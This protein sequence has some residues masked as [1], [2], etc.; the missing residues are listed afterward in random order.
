MKLFNDT[1]L[2]TNNK[3]HRQNLDLPD[4]DLMLHEGF[5]DKKESDHYYA[6]LLKNTPW[7]E[8]ELTVY[9]KTHTIPRM[10]AWYE[11]KSNAGADLSAP[12]WT[13]ELLAIKKKV[14]QECGHKFNSVLLNL[15]RDGKDGVGWHSDKEED[16][17]S[18]QVIASVSFGET[19]LFKL[20]HKTQK[21]LPVQELPL[22]HG[23]LLLMAGTTQTHWEHHVPKTAKDILP[24]VNLTFRQVKREG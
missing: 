20:R 13:P 4:A 6:T 8:S 7:K 17:G 23:T 9:D 12:F 21:E 14:E 1:D 22:T 10:V 15:Y 18:N 3:P 5:F 2:F 19:R 24:R 11:D 16:F